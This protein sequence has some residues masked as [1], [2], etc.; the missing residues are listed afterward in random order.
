MFNVLDIE[1]W[2]LNNQRPPE[3]QGTRLHECTYVVIG[4]IHK[5]FQNGARS[6]E[7]LLQIFT[8]EG[9]LSNT[10]TSLLTV[11]PVK[12]DGQSVEEFEEFKPK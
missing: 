2:I 4:P 1:D 5:E 12:I 9:Y 10:E 8:D 7:Q 11:T 3:Q 6:V